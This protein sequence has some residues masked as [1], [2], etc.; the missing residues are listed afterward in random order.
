MRIAVISSGI[1]P[2]PAYEGGA[3][4]NLV[5]FYLAENERTGKYDITVYSVKPSSDVSVPHNEH[6]HYKY[7]DVSSFVSR[8]R[9]VLFSKYHKG[10]FYHP[11]VEYFL[12]RI[13]PDLIRQKYDV[14]V[15]ENRPGFAIPL[16][17]KVSSKILL[18][19][20]TDTIH[21]GA[22]CAAEILSC[23]D[24]VIAISDYIRN[25][26]LSVNPSVPVRRVYNGID[27]PHYVSSCSISRSDLGFSESDFV[28]V[29]CGRLVVEKGVTQILEA[30]CALAQEIPTL[31]LLV[32]GSSFYGEDKRQDPYVQSLYEMSDKVRDR[33]SFT[34]YVP[35][36]KIP[37]Y[38]KACDVAVLPSIVDEAFGLTVLESMAC[39]LPVVTTNAGGIPEVCG[40]SAIMVERGEDMADRL[41]HALRKLWYDIELRKSMAKTSLE[42]SKRF[43]ADHYADEMLRAFGAIDL[44]IL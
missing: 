30:L 1:L 11:Y 27:I 38:L 42:Y 33:I 28:L 4:E 16:R 9:R 36:D 18:H 23:C 19:L 40:D 25:R 17:R 2:I 6:V 10:D 26:V 31:K 39:G 5:D 15:L 13:M 7:V 21:P 44:L 24:G 12:A 3:V 41:I 20:H 34:G 43:G 37:S 35:Y 32:I 29:Y 14:I 8:V 22:R